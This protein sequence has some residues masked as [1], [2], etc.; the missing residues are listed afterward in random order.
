MPERALRLL[1]K[2][3]GESLRAEWLWTAPNPRVG[4]IALKGGHIVGRGFHHYWGGPHAEEMALRDAGAWD[5]LENRPLSGLVEQM[6]VTLEPCSSQGKRPS[7]VSLLAVAQIESVI[8]GALDPN[9]KHQ[10][11]GL[12]VLKEMGM[13]VSC[14]G[15]EKTFAGQ[16]PSFLRALQNPTR[17]WILLKWASTVD[18]KLAA[19]SGLSQWI[20]GPE[21]RAEVHQLRANAD[22]VMVGKGTLLADSPTLTSR[23]GNTA[24]QQ[25]PWRVLVDPPASDKAL[26]GILSTPNPVIWIC[27]NSQPLEPWLRPNDEILRTKRPAE[28]RLDLK[29][30]M[31]DLKKDFGIEKL[32]V[33]G[34]PRLHGEL[35]ALGMVDAVVRYEAPLLLGGPES[36]CLGK[37]FQ[38]PAEALALSEPCQRLLGRD[39]RTAWC[40]S[41]AP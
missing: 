12:A 3:Q 40:V 24:E 25:Q 17:P 23:C 15:G 38:S 14:L 28:G 26:A 4:A 33:E 36:A 6:V 27:E 39:Q 21:S 31:D 9:P 29:G 20:S 1:E 18:G 37:S 35:L 34:G 8:V 19:A 2:A 16:N 22:A 32:M 5:D 41:P 13:E 30:A 11:N 10:G 7:C